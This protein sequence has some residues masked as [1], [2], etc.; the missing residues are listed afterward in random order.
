M[1]FFTDEMPED[2]W[3]C[4][5]FKNDL[6]QPCGLAPDDA[7]DTYYYRGDDADEDAVCPLESLDAHD[8]E[9][10]KQVCK[11]IVKQATKKL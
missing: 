1:K 3:H 9:V 2:C 7:F 5:C 10:T 11:E 6:E 4:P 8:I